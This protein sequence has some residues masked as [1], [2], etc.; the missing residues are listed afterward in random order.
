MNH[1]DKTTKRRKGILKIPKY[2]K[3]NKNTKFCLKVRQDRALP[4]LYD[5]DIQNYDASHANNKQV[6][7]LVQFSS[8]DIASANSELYTRHHIITCAK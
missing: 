6:R 8:C 7:P 1:F 4:R 2:R 5:V 3:N